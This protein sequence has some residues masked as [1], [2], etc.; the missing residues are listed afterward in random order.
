MKHQNWHKQ[1]TINCYVFK[2]ELRSAG[3]WTGSHWSH[4]VQRAYPN[5]KMSATTATIGQDQGISSCSLYH[6]PGNQAPDRG[7]M[8]THASV[9]ASEVTNRAEKK[10]R[11]TYTTGRCQQQP[12]L[13]TID[14]GILWIV[15]CEIVHH[16]RSRWWEQKQWNKRK[17]M[18]TLPTIATE[19]K[20]GN[21]IRIKPIAKLQSP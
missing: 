12:T 5:I 8:V 14:V 19:A 4:G 2:T 7:S 17:C 20:T 16:H 6:I 15:P 9:L 11:G 21:K 13:Y 3:V 1:C 18:I 10:L